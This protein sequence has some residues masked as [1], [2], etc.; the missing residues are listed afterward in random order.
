MSAPSLVDLK[1][2]VDYALDNG[3]EFTTYADEFKE[4]L[5]PVKK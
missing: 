4:K 2:F 1:H 3:H 5:T